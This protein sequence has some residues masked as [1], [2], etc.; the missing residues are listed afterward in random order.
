MTTE[1]KIR[2]RFNHY[3]QMACARWPNVAS[4]PVPRIEFF[5]KGT[6]AGLAYQGQWKVA[7]NAPLLAQSDSML[8]NVVSHEIAHM[9]C[10]ANGWGRGHGKWFVYA[11]RALGGTGE[12]CFNAA[13]EGV[14]VV[15]G[16]NTNQHLYR[17]AKGEEAWIGPKYH[18][19][20]QRDRTGFIVTHPRFASGKGDF[21]HTD[22]TGQSRKK[23]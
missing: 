9:V 12:R 13:T 6:A 17:N 21:N 14:K 5:A 10:Y 20:F 23:Y 11:H 2:E 22:Y 7:F 19:K 15:P 1:T 18:A 16:R 8:D 3:W 4:K